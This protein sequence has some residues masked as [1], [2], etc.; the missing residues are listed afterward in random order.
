LGAVLAGMLW[1]KPWAP[2]TALDRF[3]APVLESS[4]TVLFCIG[5]RAFLA[6]AQEPFQSPNPDIPLV[7]KTRAD[8]TAPITLSDLYYMGSQNV[9]LHDV[10]TLGR[11]AGLLHTKGKSYRILGQS[12]TSFAD[13]RDG[14]VILV[15]AFNNDWTMRLTG[16]SPMRFSF[17]REGTVSW[18]RDRQNP[19]HR[20]HPVNFDTP[21]LNLT[22]DFAVI[23]RVLDPTTDRMV[24]IAA[25]L[26]GYGTI[27]AG[28]FLTDPGYM[29]TAAKQAPEN[30]DHKN[31]QLIIATKVINGN[32]GPPRV[33]DR[34]FW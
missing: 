4:S 32:S 33:V 14:P 26:T 10:R 1:L 29:E 17:E 22:E 15:G 7:S 25:G 2:R 12:S 13:L 34:Y 30:W 18:I 23:S 9:A 31:M 24:V 27:A 20:D 6:S 3:W 16:S 28:E 21:Y 8:S 19:T 11:L 5:Q